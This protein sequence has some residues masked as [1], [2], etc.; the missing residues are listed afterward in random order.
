MSYL[1]VQVFGNV[2]IQLNQ[3]SQ[4]GADSLENLTSIYFSPDVV[5]T[6]NILFR[7]W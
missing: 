3:A 5:R 1:Q 4:C 7:Y 6:D 2:L